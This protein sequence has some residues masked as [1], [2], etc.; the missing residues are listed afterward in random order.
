[1]KKRCNNCNEKIKKI[2]SFCPSCGIPLKESKDEWGMLG[3]NDSIENELPKITGGGLMG[4]MMNKML[5]NAIKMLEQEMNKELGEIEKQPRTKIKLMVNGKEINPYEEKR[6]NAKILPI[7]FS[8]E[9]LKKWKKMEKKEPKSKLRRVDDKIKYELEIP[10]VKSIQDISIVKLENS[11]EVRAIG[12][13][14]GY[15]KNIS[16]D[17]PLKKYTLLKGILTL[18]L[19]AE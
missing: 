12:K 19:D 3:K 15:V 13:K 14:T 18:E 7:E 2:Y 17:L 6:E 9:N 4:N 10:E 16:I 5:G 8:D 11:L 1:M